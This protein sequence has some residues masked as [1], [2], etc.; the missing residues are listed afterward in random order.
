M[1]SRR[2]AFEARAK[3]LQDQI[4]D[5]TKQATD[6]K[7][8]ADRIVAELSRLQ[9]Q[10]RTFEPHRKELSRLA[11]LRE[12]GERQLGE[13]D[14]RLAEKR[15]ELTRLQEEIRTRE[16]QRQKLSL[17]PSGDLAVPV[18]V[19]TIGDAKSIMPKH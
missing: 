3:E 8:E 11:S 7:R 4:R 9:D 5:Q 14:N 15:A 6:G 13:V 12:Q 18:K 1:D 17:L 16:E 2:A 10:S 19:E